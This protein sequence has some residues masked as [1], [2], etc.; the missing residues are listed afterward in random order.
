VGIISTRRQRSSPLGH[1][2]QLVNS[3]NVLPRFVLRRLKRK[4]ARF[5]AEHIPQGGIGAEIGVQRGLFAHVIMHT[6]R[7]ETLHLIDPWYLAGK[8]WPWALGNRSTMKALTNLMRSFEDELVK[9]EVV[10]H[11]GYDFDVLPALPDHY[12]DWI[13]LDSSH[14]YED[15]A[16]ELQ[17]L[18]RKVKSSGII[19]G[20]NWEPDPLHAFH[21]V[22]AA[23]EEFVALEGYVYVNAKVAG[24]TQFAIK[25]K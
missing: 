14:T 4:R 20:D 5:L 15:T 17:I 8:E 16:R 21:G 3:I 24:L 22:Y 9:G 12:F 25:A 18:K 23:V 13:Y 10:L 7:P 6:L 2:Y 1:A 19:S 11:I